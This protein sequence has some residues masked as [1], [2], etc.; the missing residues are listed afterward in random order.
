M[1]YG[2]LHEHGPDSLLAIGDDVVQLAVAFLTV[3]MP[4]ARQIAR[5]RRASQ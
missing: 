4:P 3:R 2:Q 5:R 1:I